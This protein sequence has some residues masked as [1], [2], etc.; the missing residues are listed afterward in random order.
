MIF[1]VV[2]DFKIRS[3]SRWSW[4]RY[5]DSI[6]D[7]IRLPKDFKIR[8]GLQ[9]ILI[10]DSRFDSGHGESKIPFDMRLDPNKILRFDSKI[11]SNLRILLIL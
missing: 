11:R 8:L 2:K 10:F 3:G 7:S 9:N 5:Q 4:V 1:N 6:Q